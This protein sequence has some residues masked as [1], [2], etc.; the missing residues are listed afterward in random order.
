MDDLR[1]LIIHDNGKTIDEVKSLLSYMG[2]GFE[3]V[4][5]VEAGLEM[6]RSGGFNVVII[7]ALIPNIDGI[8][9][10]KRIASS[11]TVEWVIA[12]TDNKL[13]ERALSAIDAERCACFNKPV[14]ILD[15]RLLI[16]KISEVYFLKKEVSDKTK[17]VS[18]LEVI[19]E[20]V[21][22]TM[23]THDE[24]TL[25]WNIARL[26]NEK[27]FFYNVNIFLMDEHEERVVLRAFAGGFGED[28]YVGYSLKLGEGIVGWVSKNCE[29][30]LVGDVRKEPRRIQGFS[31]EENI[32][33][34]LAVP[35]MLN[36]RVLGVLHVESVELNA[37]SSEDIMVL[38]TVADQM[39]LALEK[40]RLSRDST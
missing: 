39:A 2:Y 29:P 9:V 22:E 26:I 34:E 5:D 18:H 27:L 17:R 30:L 28:L 21:T 8:E 15:L 11:I 1:F 10:L 13:K 14:D 12:F 6:V 32:L 4:S 3:D 33:S 40:Q 23:L 25:L 7:D 31:F 38:E 37:F 19:Y 36:G 16:K 35:L 20:I 24:D